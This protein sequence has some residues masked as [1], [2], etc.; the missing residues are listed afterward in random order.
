[1]FAKRELHGS[2]EKTTI[3][4]DVAWLTFEWVFDATMKADNSPIQTKGRETQLWRK[5]NN[6]WKLVHIHYSGMPVTGEK[7]GF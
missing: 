2:K 6:Q 7:Q 5:I 1:M 4:G 3:Y